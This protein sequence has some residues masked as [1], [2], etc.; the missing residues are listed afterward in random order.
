M[1]NISKPRWVAAQEKIALV[2]W[3]EIT[4]RGQEAAEQ[5]GKGG[6]WGEKLRQTQPH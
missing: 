3:E 2:E 4:H 1:D 6:V 5:I